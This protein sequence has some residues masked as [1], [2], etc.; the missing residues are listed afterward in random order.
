MI[1]SSGMQYSEDEYLLLSG[2]QHFVFC[3]RQWALIHIEQ[4]WEENLRTVE[5]KI[6]H[7]NVHNNEFNETR[8]DLIIARAMAISSSKLGIS[9]EC[10]VVE[11]KRCKNGVPLYG[12]EGV[13]S[14]T[15]IEYKRGEPK[16]DES[17]I[18]QLT[19][20][21]MCLEEMLCCEIYA[22]FL[23]YGETRRRLKVEFSDS[24]RERTERIITEMHKFFR[25][26]YTPKVKRTKACNACSLKD[27]CLP[28]LCSKRNASEYISEMMEEI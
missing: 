15:P 23:F 10:D 16:E 8:G 3:R 6:M 12:K 19:A 24:L 20:Q 5:G 22:G 4:Q 18:M 28:V 14:V 13:Y 27:V 26:K 1:W 7:R 2:I 17:D 25:D 9:G 21:A 11:F